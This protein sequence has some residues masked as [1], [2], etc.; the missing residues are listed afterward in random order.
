MRWRSG[1]L[2]FQLR[3]EHQVVI[4]RLVD[5]C[6]RRLR[7]A[8]VEL[9]LGSCDRFENRVGSKVDCAFIGDRRPCLADYVFVDPIG[10]FVTDACRSVSRLAS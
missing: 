5:R 1:P 6:L 9:T 3:V 4:E 10:I 2:A 8:D 7:R